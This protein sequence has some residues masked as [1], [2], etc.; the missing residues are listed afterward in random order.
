MEADRI[1]RENVQKIAGLQVRGAEAVSRTQQAQGVVDEFNALRQQYGITLTGQ[2]G[3]ISVNDAGRIETSFDYYGGGDV[4]GFKKALLKEFGTDAIGRVFGATNTRV[5][6]AEARAERLR[7]QIR[8]LGGIPAFAQGGTHRGGLARV[9]EN[10]IELV[11]PSRIYN[12]ADTKAMLDNRAVVKELRELR[13][14]VAELRKDKHRADF[15][16]IRETQEIKRLA[17]KQDVVGVKI[18]EE[19]A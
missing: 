14:E 11:A 6:N 7:Q 19:Q 9:G 17:Q 16:K 5:G 15:Q 13:K 4:V 10:D 2:K 12:P 18:Q 3:T 1:Q 8:E